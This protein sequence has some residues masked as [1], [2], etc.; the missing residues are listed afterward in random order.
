MRNDRPHLVEIGAH[1][2]RFH[3]ATA[4]IHPVHIAAN[5]VDF[6][7]MRDK[8]IGVRQLPAR[9]GV[10]RKALVDEREGRLAERI[11]QIVIETANLSGEEQSLIDHRTRRH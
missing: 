5:R 10:G 11:A 8:A 9:E 6:A 7:I 3:R 2:V 1:Q 4:R